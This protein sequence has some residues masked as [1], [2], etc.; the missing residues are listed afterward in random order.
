M[1]AKESVLSPGNGE[2]LKISWQKTDKIRAAF[3]TIHFGG[4]NI[5]PWDKQT[6]AHGPDLACG[7]FSYSL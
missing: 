1:S 2:L 3:Q 6:R 7:L 4:S 5:E